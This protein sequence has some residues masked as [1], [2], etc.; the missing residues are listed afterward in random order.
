MAERGARCR[1]HTWPTSG[2]SCKG[3]FTLG[4]A[5]SFSWLTSKVPPFGSKSKLTTC[6]QCETPVSGPAGG[7][8]LRK[9]CHWRQPCF[10]VDPAVPWHSMQQYVLWFSHWVT[11]CRFS[12]LTSKMPLWG[13]M[14]ILTLT[15]ITTRV[16][17][18]KTSFLALL[19]H[20]T[21]YED[22]VYSTRIISPVPGVRSQA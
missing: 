17:N 2:A 1:R 16:T 7:V 10:V 4:D 22:C 11:H 12:G 14:L 6:H 3:V 18:V 21:G 15:S 13:S 19:T 8:T 5:R 9:H 20:V